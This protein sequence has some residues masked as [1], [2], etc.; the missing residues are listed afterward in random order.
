M[1]KNKASDVFFYTG[2][3]VSMKTPNGFAQLGEPLEHGV[4]HRVAETVVDHLEVVEIEIEKGE[5]LAPGQPILDLRLDDPVAGVGGLLL[6]RD[7]V[8]VGRVGRER[9]AHTV[10]LGARLQQP[11]DLAHPVGA[12]LLQQMS[13][14]APD[15]AGRPEDEV[16][17]FHVG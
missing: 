14:R 12:L 8:E 4:S 6:D 13:N 7:G 17:L 15:P 1:V 10:F 5:H 11:Q 16:E 9:D 3:K 2:A